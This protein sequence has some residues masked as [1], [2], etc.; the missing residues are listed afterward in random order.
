MAKSN[1]KHTESTKDLYFDDDYEDFGYNVK[2]ARRYSNQRKRI[3]KFKD[4]NEDFE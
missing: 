4:Y 1:R 2:N 3:K